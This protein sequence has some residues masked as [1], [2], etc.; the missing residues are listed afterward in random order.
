MMVIRFGLPL[1]YIGRREKQ[2]SQILF[3]SLAT[4]SNGRSTKQYETYRNS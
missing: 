3:S 1:I 4:V 2:A